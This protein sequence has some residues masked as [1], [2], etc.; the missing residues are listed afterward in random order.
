MWFR[1]LTILPVLIG[2]SVN[3]TPHENIKKI[4]E[5]PVKSSLY[6]DNFSL[7]M[8]WVANANQT[9]YDDLTTKNIYSTKSENQAYNTALMVK[10][11]Q[12]TQQ[13][14]NDETQGN[15]NIYIPSENGD[16]TE[17]TALLCY[18][19][20]PYENLVN[21]QDNVQL[22][23]ALRLRNQAQVNNMKCNITVLTST[24]SYWVNY[25]DLSNYF[26]PRQLYNTYLD[27]TSSLNGFMYNEQNY[28]KN[29][30]IAN[31]LTYNDLDISL[32]IVNNRTNYILVYIQPEIQLTGAQGDTYTLIYGDLFNTGFT[33]KQWLLFTNY[34][35]N[36]GTL[37]N[38]MITGQMIVGSQTSEVIDL[39]GIMFYVLTMPFT[40]IS[41]AFNLTLFEGTP[42]QI[43]ISNLFLSIIAIFV[44][45]F[46]ISMLIKRKL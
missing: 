24:E 8:Q 46:L 35:T 15:I 36:T 11:Y 42:Y 45:I 5:Q 34:D 22:T 18:Q 44:F 25:M 20:T 30:D 26:V 13:L 14:I 37:T 41:V 19:I 12:Y 27:A 28:T 10:E 3:A 40:F 1:A 43:N 17:T 7:E 9:A 21:V 39:P 33:I 31:N 6:I 32:N 38:N 2:T 16:K 4:D 29:L 23:L